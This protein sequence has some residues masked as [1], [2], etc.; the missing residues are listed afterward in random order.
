[1]PAP[2]IFIAYQRALLIHVLVSGSQRASFCFEQ[3]C[4]MLHPRH[5]I[6]KDV[7]SIYSH[8]HRL[9]TFFAGVLLTY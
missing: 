4:S 7:A 2:P 5:F 3:E 9:A 6:V 8:G 1:M